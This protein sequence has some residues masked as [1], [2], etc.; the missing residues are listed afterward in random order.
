MFTAEDPVAKPPEPWVP[1]SMLVLTVAD[2]VRISS[3]VVAPVRSMSL[4]FRIW[5]EPAASVAVRLMLEPVISTR[6]IFSY[7]A[8][9]AKADCEK[10][11]AR[12]AAIALFLRIGVWFK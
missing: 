3:A 5:I 10:A 2:E 9:W 12:A 8:C 1:E 11:T 7:G 4:R 6:W